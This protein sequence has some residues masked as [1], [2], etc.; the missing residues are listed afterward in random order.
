VAGIYLHIP[1]CKQ[2]CHYCDF[3]FSTNQGQRTSLIMAMVKEMAI[4]KKYLQGEAIHT[5]YFGGGTPSLLF[6][7]EF[8]LL[9]S[10]LHKNFT[11]DVDAEITV[12]ANPDDLDEPKL[13]MLRQLSINRLSI[14]IQSF[15]DSILTYLNRAHTSASAKQC[16]S[17]ARDAGF[18]NISI[19]LIY[20]I[21][22][23]TLAMWKQDIAQALALKPEHISCYSLTIEQKTAFGKWAKR[24]KLKIVDD[25]VAAEHLEIL[26]EQLEHAGYEH[27]EISNF[28]KPEF[29]S[30]HNSSYWKQAKYLGIGPSAHSYNGV[31][32]QYTVSNNQQYLQSLEKGE[33]PLEKE[34]LT[35]ADHINEFILTSLRTSWGCNT[36]QLQALYSYDLLTDQETYIEQLLK[37]DQATIFNK[38]LILTKK[39]KLLADKIASDLF[40][41]D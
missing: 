3:H 7:Q 1:F 10:G 28:A 15:H 12:E 13:K 25:E 17:A 23:Q 33:V 24:G 16:V 34:V 32:R 11:L 20:A 35:R 36:S 8:E 26:M 38:H 4:Q 37:Q 31:S 41:I 22:N 14:G 40:I 5:L 6:E 9:F 27:Y 29:Q 30:Q 2:A 19:D 21:P 39:G 18:S